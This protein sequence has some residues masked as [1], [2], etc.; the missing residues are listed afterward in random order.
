[1]ERRGPH[2][3]PAHAPNAASHLRPLQPPL[4]ALGSPRRGR[5]RMLA[6]EARAAIELCLVE[7][8]R[9]VQ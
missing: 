3:K 4:R 8:D 7:L 2:S 1:M 6:E 9:E 5:C